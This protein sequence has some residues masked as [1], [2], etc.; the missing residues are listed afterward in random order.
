MLFYNNL[1]NICGQLRKNGQVR[2]FL[3]V[4]GATLYLHPALEKLDPIGGELRWFQTGDALH[5]FLA[6]R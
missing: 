2:A 4:G 3:E 1:R 5:G 6:S